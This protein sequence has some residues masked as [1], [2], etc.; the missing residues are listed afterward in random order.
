MTMTCLQH[1][2]TKSYFD[3][4]ST[5]TLTSSRHYSRLFD[6]DLFSSSSSSSFSTTQLQPLLT[7]DKAT[8]DTKVTIILAEGSNNT[9][10]MHWWSNLKLGVFSLHILRIL[11]PYIGTNGDREVDH[12]R[13]CG[14]GTITVYECLLEW[15]V[16]LGE[17]VYY[18]TTT[19]NPHTHKW[20][21]IRKSSLANVHYASATSQ[22]EIQQSSS[23]TL[24]FWRQIFVKLEN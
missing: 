21:A 1:W 6:V 8:W 14:E 2:P 16:S 22:Y 13:K 20:G 17:Y 11:Q 5:P 10:T 24:H 18:H 19:V 23:W 4:S 3:E 15:Q 12:I 9:Y 7:A